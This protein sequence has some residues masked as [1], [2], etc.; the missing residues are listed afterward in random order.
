MSN[1]NAELIRRAYQAY[2]NGDL[3]TML[4]LIDSD[5]EW[6]YLDP[7]LEHPPRRAAPYGEDPR[8]R[9]ALARRETPSRAWDLCSTIGLDQQPYSRLGASPEAIREPRPGV[10]NR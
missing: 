1:E 9:E 7:T 6:T 2:A 10:P 8:R 4:E 5:L 3:A